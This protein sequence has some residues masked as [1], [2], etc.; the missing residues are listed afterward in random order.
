MDAHGVGLVVK[1]QRDRE[2]GPSHRTCPTATVPC[3]RSF[4]CAFSSRAKRSRRVASV[5]RASAVSSARAATVAGQSA[6]GGLCGP[7]RR[8]RESEPGSMPN[9]SA[10]CVSVTCTRVLTASVA[11]LNDHRVRWAMRA[12]FSRDV[13]DA[14]QATFAQS[15]VQS[16]DVVFSLWPRPPSRCMLP[17]PPPASPTTPI[18]QEPR[19]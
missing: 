9:R 19:Q 2:S 16:K 10:T 1:S 11:C 5:R 12:V 14:G 7:S 13:C 15:N 3:E 17:P 18:L 4:P 6:G 8:Q